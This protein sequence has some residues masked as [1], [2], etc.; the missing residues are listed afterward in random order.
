MREYIYFNTSLLPFSVSDDMEDATSR[1]NGSRASPSRPFGPCV[2]RSFKITKESLFNTFFIRN[3][4]KIAQS[5]SSNQV[6]GVLRGTI[7]S[8]SNTL[9]IF[10]L[11]TKISNQFSN[12]MGFGNCHQHW[13]CGKNSFVRPPLFLLEALRSCLGPSHF[14]TSKNP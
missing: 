5:R 8:F 2:T 12:Y 9:L 14:R 13:C 10:G 3:W 4:F 6:I 1:S 11:E 7:A